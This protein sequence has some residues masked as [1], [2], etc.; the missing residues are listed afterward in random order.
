M[1]WES[2]KL[3]A[4]IYQLQLMSLESLLLMQS[5]SNKLLVLIY[6][7]QLMSRITIIDAIRIK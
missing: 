3:L 7:L 1:Q 5:E 4:L 6:Q 2:N